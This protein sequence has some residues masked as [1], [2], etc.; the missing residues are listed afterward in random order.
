MKA[1][2]RPLDRKAKIDAAELDIQERLLGIDRVTKV[3]KGGRR[4][5]FR[6]LM[7]VGDG[8]GRVGIGVA[9]AAGVP[10]AIRKAAAV[11]RKG[12][13][14]V[15][16]VETTIPHEIFAKFEA[17][18]VLLKPARQG[19]GTIASNTVRAVLELAGISDI[20]GKTLGSTNKVNV[21]KATM[22]ALSNLKWPEQAGA[23][24]VSEAVTEE[25]EEESEAE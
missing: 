24:A 7:V 16:I 13:I 14:N 12:L 18:K 3:V 23:E 25:E 1:V 10:E 20:V 15:P 6:A 17:S 19:R 2:T 4:L 22:L 21:A 9:K 11:G 5:R 8:K